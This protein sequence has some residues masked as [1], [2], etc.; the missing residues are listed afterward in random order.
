MEIAVIDYNPIQREGVKRT[1]ERQHLNV[2][3]AGQEL[4]DVPESAN[5]LLCFVDRYENQ[6]CIII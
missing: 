1:L 4:D 3:F 6:K 5:V 2:V